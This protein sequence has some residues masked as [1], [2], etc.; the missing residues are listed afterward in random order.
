MRRN[1][2]PTS[3]APLA[4][5]AELSG[6]RGD[7]LAADVGE[8]MSSGIVGGQPGDGP[9]L[10]DIIGEQEHFV[11]ETQSAQVRVRDEPCAATLLGGRKER[12]ALIE[13]GQGPQI[14]HEGLEV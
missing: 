12:P 13:L 4:D 2:N 11:V 6:T 14:V 8:S 9:L 7:G 10:V 1:V 3:C 5:D